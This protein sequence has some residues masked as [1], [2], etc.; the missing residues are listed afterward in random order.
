V[1]SA[2]GWL[3]SM[4][5]ESVAAREATRQIPPGARVE[6]LVRGFGQSLIVEWSVL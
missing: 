6:A 3:L 5:V 2:I 4:L 1:S